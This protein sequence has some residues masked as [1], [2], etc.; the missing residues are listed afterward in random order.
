MEE[1]NER[2]DSNLN[3]LETLEKRAENTERIA[4]PYS[5][6]RF[7][8]EP[9]RKFLTVEDKEY[10][11][12]ED[13]YDTLL[14]TV[15]VPKG[16][17][18]RMPVTLLEENVNFWIRQKNNEMFSALVN[19]ETDRIR[20]FMNPNLSYVST[21]DVFNEVAT[22]VG[23]DWE[24]R[25][26]E[27]TDSVV[28]VAF[29][30]DRESGGHVGD[31]S[32]AGLSLVHSDS[33]MVAPRFDS[34]LLRLVCTN[35]Q[36]RPVSGRK[37]RVTG[38]DREGILEQ[39]GQFTE[40]SVENLELMIAGYERLRDQHVDNVARIVQRICQENNL[41]S[42][43]REALILT[44]QSPTFLATMPE[45]NMGTMFDVVNLLTWVATHNQEIPDNH[46][47]HL[48]EIAGSISAT[49]ETRCESCGSSVD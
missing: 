5:A 11:L 32:A 49:G 21:I 20:S 14:K 33:W 47:M 41:P 15:H 44:M 4:A 23:T 16:Y 18:N 1:I 27:I 40:I 31:V 39:V 13:G 24:L 6:V 43:V 8:A 9:Q 26:Y 45:S 29:T 25:N 42:K 36:T 30:T 28:K 3:I 48:R 35:G 34:Y 38:S 19:K 22:H 17:A 46:R 7:V 37:F 10:T 12:T 2:I